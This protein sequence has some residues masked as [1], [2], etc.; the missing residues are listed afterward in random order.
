[1][2]KL[3]IIFFY[4]FFY[5]NIS[6]EQNRIIINNKISEIHLVIQG[7]GNQ[8]IISDNFNI[9]PS[10]VLING[11][12]D[13]SCQKI[14]NL[15]GDKNNIT[16]KF[17]SQIETCKDM[18]KSLNNIIEI[19]LSYFDTSKVT[20]ISYMLSS[21][22]NLE[23]INF[24]NINTSS[25]EDMSHLFDNC[26]KLTSI[27]LSN[28][29]TSK[30]K[31][32]IGTFHQC[33]NLEKINFGNIN[34]SSLEDMS[35]LFYSCSK[36]T[37]IDLSNFDTSKVTSMHML[38]YSCKYLEIIDFGNIN[39]SSLESFGFFVTYC[40]NLTSLDLSKFDTSKIKNM[41]WSFHGCSKLKYLDL[42]NFEALKITNIQSLFTDCTSLIY[43]NLKS[44][45]INISLGTNKPFEGLSNKT[46]FC[47][48]NDEL[49][50]NLLSNIGINS[51]CSDDS[52]KEN[53]KID[54]NNNTCINS[55]LQNGYE[56]EYNNVCYFKC[57]K[58]TLVNGNICEYN[59][60]KIYSQN[61][62][63]CL[64]KTPQG[65]YYD[66]NEEI[67]KKC[68]EKCKFCY[69][70]GNETNNNCIE[71]NSN[72]T[73]LDDFINDTQCY[74]KCEYFYYFDELNNY[75]CTLNNSCPDKYNKTIK[76]KNKCIDDCTK[77]NLYKC[78]Y[79]NNC[80]INCPIFTTINDYIEIEEE[81]ENLQNE[82]IIIEDTNQEKDI[83]EESFINY[84]NNEEIITEY[85]FEDVTIKEVDKEQMYECS[86]DDLLIN[87]C[88]IKDINNNSDI[89]NFIIENILPSYSSNSDKSQI[90]VINDTIYHITSVK[91]ELELL[92]GN[93]TDNY[94][95]SII[96]L[97][98]CDN[99]LKEEYNISLNDSLIYLKKQKYTKKASEN[100]IQ[101]EVFEPYN[102]NKLNLSVCLGTLINLYV[103]IELSEETEKISEQMKELGYNMFDI[104][105]KFYQDICT[106]FKS[107]SNTD[108]L[109][110][111][112]IDYI[113]N[114]EDTQCQSN[115]IFSGYFLESQYINCSCE[116]N[117]EI[118]DNNKKDKFT[119]KK[120]Y[121]SFFDVL[122][123]SNYETLKCSKLVFSKNVLTENKGSI[124][125]LIY[126]CLNLSCLIFFIIKGI[127]PLKLKS[128][129]NNNDIFNENKNKEKYN[130]IE[131]KSV[132]K[133]NKRKNGKEKKGK[134]LKFNLSYPPKKKTN[135]QTQVDANYNYYNKKLKKLNIR[136]AKIVREIFMRKDNYQINP[137]KN[138]NNIK[139]SSKL[140]SYTE[141]GKSL[142]I[143]K[144]VLKDLNQS[145]IKDN[146]LKK[147]Q[148]NL[149]IKEENKIESQIQNQKTLDDYE[150]NDL[151]YE[152]ALKLDK[153][154]LIQIYL[155]LIKREHIIIFTFLICNDYNLL[156]IKISR[157]IFLMATDMAM[158]T[159]FFSD[160]SMHK[161][162][163]NYGKYD[164]IQQIP[165]IVYSTIISQL[166]EVFLC[167]LSLTDKHIYEILKILNES[168]NKN[169]INKKFKLIKLKLIIFFLFT[170]IFFGIYWYMVASFCAVYENTQI[171]FIKDS[172]YSFLLSILY[173][174]ILYIIPS[175]LRIC[176]IRDEKGESNCL[177]KLSDIIPFF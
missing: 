125:L 27:D 136:T 134:K 43:L 79:D 32:M 131:R 66:S 22:S 128:I 59:L 144:F 113:Y 56:F 83:I 1:M 161:L 70:E 171:T 135:L 106:P 174:F 165:Q 74:E 72:Y 142:S 48:E 103:K 105:D 63:E 157:F 25:V 69:G 133:I 143:K 94:S 20:D 176:A 119:T 11:I 28:F 177:Y 18:F 160:E 47:I 39:T 175:A 149:V 4:F 126:F 14:C 120:L 26:Y 153:R 87:Q 50:N 122:K 46:K 146:E 95:L 173:P 151:E 108:I 55:C 82:S 147:Q 102:K 121:E 54:I 139:I 78:E 36:L 158:N 15:E 123:Y 31:N 80:Y 42:S 107:S 77:D 96:D 81:N 41:K 145:D 67:Y 23:I 57:P 6:R 19:D 117:E 109:L 164:I 166:L 33:S 170:N 104:N 75:H 127:N 24:G 58:G 7:N 29:D 12:K 30:V 132:L 172:I 52:F 85:K 124:I 45:Q 99:I 148:N 167:F 51:D 49:K 73:L 110:S 64:G 130:N 92:K 10:E 137:H 159:F 71:C 8:N 3:L 91:N 115:C 101:Y 9:L 154:T 86:N 168:N 5:E 163:L 62:I 89:Y 112:R 155:S 98:E 84:K 93:I 88:F 90:F 152:E 111:D 169:E 38:F 100:N 53:I 76:N 138:N 40:Y 2:K 150:L 162:F 60:C 35:S 140:N 17:E 65:Y 141:R 97:G 16:L 114:N 34:T 118:N 13:E 68:F 116:V 61:L 37:S 156:Y 129:E 44:F 21:C